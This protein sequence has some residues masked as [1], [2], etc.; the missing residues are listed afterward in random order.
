M[1]KGVAPLNG[2]CRGAGRSAVAR[3]SALRGGSVIAIC[4]ALM[5][6][7]LPG[8]VVGIG[9]FAMPENSL[10]AMAEGSAINAPHVRVNFGTP[11]LTGHNPKLSHRPLAA[12]WRRDE[13]AK[14][15][16]IADAR[17][18]VASVEWAGQGGV[19]ADAQY[20]SADWLSPD[21][22]EAQPD[23]GFAL[24]PRASVS[25]PLILSAV[26]HTIASNADLSGGMARGGGVGGDE[27]LL[28]KPTIGYLPVTLDGDV[29]TQLLAQPFSQVSAE[30]LASA[31]LAPSSGL[32]VPGD[33]PVPFGAGSASPLD[34]EPLP[35][36]PEPAPATTPATLRSRDLGSGEAAGLAVAST[37]LAL[38]EDHSARTTGD[39][40]GLGTESL[41]AFSGQVERAQRQLSNAAAA[42]RAT[43]ERSSLGHPIPSPVPSTVA[44][45]EAEV[46]EAMVFALSG[47]NGSAIAS[48]LTAPR[49]VQ[50]RSLIAALSDRFEAPELQ[51]M[52]ASSAADVFVPIDLLESAGIVLGEKLD[53]GDPLGKQPAS[54]W[55]M[56]QSQPAS[57]GAG[58]GRGALGGGLGDL[59]L[60]RSLTA[61]ASAGFDSNPFLSQLAN[62]EA[63][64]LRL[65]LAPALSR[66]SERG[67]FRLTGRLEHIE[68]LGQYD[69]LQNFGAD[70]A[71]SRKLNERLTVDG[72]L[73]FRSDFLATNLGNPFGNDETVTGNPAPPTGNDVTILGQ[74]QRRTQYGVD[75]G[76]TYDLSVRDQLR[77][78]VSGRADRFGS[79]NLVDSNFLAQRLQYSRLLDEDITIGAAIDANLIDF[80]GSGLDG[81]QT[82][83]P[84]LQ[85]NAALTPRLTLSASVGLAVTRLEFNGLEDTTTA[86]AG[87]ASL[88]RKGERSSF[89][90]NGSRQVLPAAIG[91]ALLQTTAG[92]SYSLRLS[93]RDTVQLSG[94]YATASQPIAA[95][96]GDFESI[97][98]F[99]RYERQLNERMRLFVTGGILNTAGNLPTS[100]SN[101]QGLIGI[102]MN[103]GQTR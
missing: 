65:Q 60:K 50:L 22:R 96:V 53:G 11:V 78:S 85:V 72:G 35:L 47:N 24:A 61:T 95:T 28:S 83:S 76:L 40:A 44:G 26:P 73:I 56:L 42:L 90:I 9:L 12:D 21:A 19:A 87:D 29:G 52:N 100:V 86:L 74:G 89:C 81:A 3:R 77:W 103:F 34:K 75:G 1:S 16:T 79:A 32:Q 27:I 99:A 55:A 36:V 39:V 45:G 57:G 80:T 6:R 17:H 20:P 84:Q 7:A 8:A 51:R 37:G 93:E 70:L 101:V 14:L 68:Y 13:R 92:F 2:A 30:R 82:V 69:S 49:L 97:N 54:N 102:T 67:T 71:A 23:D 4:R 94:N 66:S 25:G 38:V 46:R 58:E 18:H 31:S 63:A 88:C 48:A 62:P 10:N 15:L 98:G 64:S 59:G 41:A 43:T 91:G 33:L 5:Y